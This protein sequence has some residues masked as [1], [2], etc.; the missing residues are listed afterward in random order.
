MI[1]L[2]RKEGG[3]TRK[4]TNFESGQTSLSSSRL[5]PITVMKIP[6]GVVMRIKNQ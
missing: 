6:Y 5:H 1:I 3:S 4:I 2:S